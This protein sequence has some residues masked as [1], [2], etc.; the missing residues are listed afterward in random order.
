[1]AIIDEEK[2]VELEKRDQ[3]RRKM[4]LE[5]GILAFLRCMTRKLGL[6]NPI[7]SVTKTI[8]LRPKLF[9]L[10]TSVNRQY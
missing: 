3:I 9:T 1:L 2:I 4:P 10:L 8:I 7:L 5:G 6:I